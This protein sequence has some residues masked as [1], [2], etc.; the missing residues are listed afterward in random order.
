MSYWT[1]KFNVHRK[2]SGWLRLFIALIYSGISFLFLWYG[3]DLILVGATGEWKIVSSFRGWTLYIT[4]ISPGVAV[5]LLGASV[6]VF[7]LPRTL[8]NLEGK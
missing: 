7:G 4:S 2:D 1:E 6:L 5:I 8:R 3:V